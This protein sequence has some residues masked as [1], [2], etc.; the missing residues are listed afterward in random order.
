MSA[1]PEQNPQQ[2][3]QGPLA[4]LLAHWRYLAALGL[5]GAGAAIIIGVPLDLPRWSQVMLAAAL[6][7]TP[8]GY[9]SGNKV[10]SLLYTPSWVYIVELDTRDR[11]NAIYRVPSD[12]FGE[13]DVIE[14]EVDRVNPH[15]VFATDVNLEAGELAGVWRGTL[16]DRELMA[17]LYKVH[18]LRGT[19]EA[20]ARRGFA[21]ETQ[22]WMIV[23]E[24]TRDA[25]RSIVDTF[26]DGTLPGTGQSVNEAI[27]SALENYDMDDLAPDPEETSDEEPE[28]DF[29]DFEPE[30][31][32]PEVGVDD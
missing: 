14:G 32:E 29:S 27:D 23:R 13:L 12:Q 10:A 31:P 26:E 15:L 20:D 3:P 5:G 24:A 4:W 2:Q 8:I 22:A 16:S 9:A 1:L 6:L 30:A 28:P 17:E 19:L 18:E 11:E 7:A 21:I 25:V